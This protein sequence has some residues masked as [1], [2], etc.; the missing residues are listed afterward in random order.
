[1]I[2]TAFSFTELTPDMTALHVVDVGAAPLATAPIYQDLVDKK[3]AS[4]IAFE[5]NEKAC[6][7]FNEKT[8]PPSMCM[9]YFVGRGGP[10]IFYEMTNK[11]TSSLYKPNENIINRFSN[12]KLHMQ[13]QATHDIETRQLDDL[14][15]ETE[16]DFLKIDVQ[17]AELD[18]LI[19]A[20][21]LLPTTLV[22]QTEIE[23]LQLYENQPLFADI[24]MHI[25]AKGFQLHTIRDVKQLYYD[26]VSRTGKLLAGLNQLAWGDAIYIPDLETLRN[27]SR[28]RLLKLATI[29]HDFYGSFDLCLHILQDMAASGVDVPA[30]EYESRLSAKF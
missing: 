28:E 4:V 9:P 12:L 19:G 18:V 30:Q 11:F 24:D 5:P 6:A 15:P 13:L 23:F 10:A 22:V 16:I 25:R 29:L 21:R 20:E 2:D 27:L 7:A 1:M 8:Q 3:M 14:I 17:G 26:P